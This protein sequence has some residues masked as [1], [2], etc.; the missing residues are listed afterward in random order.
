MANN[1]DVA[2]SEKVDTLDEYGV[3]MCGSVHNQERT[4]NSTERQK[5][6]QMAFCRSAWQLIHRHALDEFTQR[7]TL[8]FCWEPKDSRP[9]QPYKAALGSGF[10]KWVGM[11]NFFPII[12]FLTWEGMLFLGLF[13]LHQLTKADRT[14][15]RCFQ[16]ARQLRPTPFA[17][18]NG[19]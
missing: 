7:L 17:E 3:R 8:V 10:E 16:R 14:M 9:K 11:S 15:P 5:I 1:L 13:M 18:R 12:E 19:A 4:N 6:T 2:R